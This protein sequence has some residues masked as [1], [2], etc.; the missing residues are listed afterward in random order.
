MQKSGARLLDESSQHAWPSPPHVPQ[1]PSAV[2]E[3]V[4]SVPPQA[5]PG[6]THLPLAQQPPPAHVLL[7]QQGWPGPPHVTR[8]PALQTALAFAPDC[9]G[10]MHLRVATSKQA[11]PVHVVMPGHARVPAT[12]Q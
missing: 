9:P 11:P 12:P 1:P 4:P 8:V 5:A 2:V 3:Q 10:A 6:P 7:A